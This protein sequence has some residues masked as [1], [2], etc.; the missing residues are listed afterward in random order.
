MSRIVDLT[1]PVV[2]GMAGLPN[3]PLY[4][5]HPVRVRA[6]TF[7][8]DAQRALVATER[9]DAA[10]DAAVVGHMNTAINM[11][12][13][14]GTHIDAPR[15]FVSAGAPI[16]KVPLDRLV[17]LR[18][19]VCDV[20]GRPAGSGITADDL[21]VCGMR[22]GPGE[23]AVIRT[24]WTDR[25]WGTPEFWSNVMYLDPSVS[26]WT[27]AH[28]VV[29]VAMDCHPEIPFWRMTMQPHQRGANHK[30]WLGAGIPMIQLLT[31]LGAVA[32]R[33]RLTALPLKL[34]NMDGSP[35]R[36]VGITGD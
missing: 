7:V 25:T 15:H 13:H 32:P 9:A 3:V 22:P 36:V 30:R 27:M 17:N 5:Q 35:A 16:D 19:V 6:V 31:N 21:E 24:G 10:A 11:V 1:L 28:G 26:E 18:A 4:E 23:C 20:T 12:T 33:F 29:A 14:I 2:S 34:A 8:D